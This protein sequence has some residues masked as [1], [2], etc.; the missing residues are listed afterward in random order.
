[1]TI[2]IGSNIASLQAQRRLG[3]AT[4]S[5]EGIYERLSSGQRIN[6]AGDDAAGLAIAS[7]LNVKSRIF[8]QAIRNINDG[9]SVH[10]IADGTVSAL[11]EITI[12]L[13][14]LAEQSANGSYSNTQRKAIDAEAQA[15]SKEFFRVS[16]SAEFNG[17]K[18]FDG[19]LA[20][21]LRL[22]VG[23]GVEGS[24]LTHVGG[25]LGTGTVT[26]VVS[27]A[28]EVGTSNAVTLDSINRPFPRN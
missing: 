8:G 22:Q 6:S 3:E 2:R 26:A 16:R 20:D 24:I 1:M 25:K 10:A 18:L 7:D 13:T 19:S 4:S 27:Y 14:E 23:V 15:L 9:I 21:G 17:Q 12:R 28:S 11:S 5:L